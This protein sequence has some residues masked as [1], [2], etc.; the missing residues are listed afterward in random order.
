MNY[1][2]I[3]ES[4]RNKYRVRQYKYFICKLSVLEAWEH[5]EK[6]LNAK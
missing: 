3:L 1:K 5:R 2:E 4:K 6:I